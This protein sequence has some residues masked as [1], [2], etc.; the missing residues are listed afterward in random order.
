MNNNPF[1]N[2]GHW[3]SAVKLYLENF[4]S[5]DPKLEFH[6]ESRF[7]YVDMYTYDGIPFGINGASYTLELF[8]K[9]NYE[10]KIEPVIS[11]LKEW[12]EFKKFQRRFIIKT[13]DQNDSTSFSFDAGVCQDVEGFQRF[14]KDYTPTVV[15]I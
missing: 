2:G 3:N 8:F 9:G 4:F 14:F 5:S 13:T 11:A 12:N 6:S 10:E 1:I 15:D 7:L